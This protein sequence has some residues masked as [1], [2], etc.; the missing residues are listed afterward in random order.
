M[1]NTGNTS[2][3]PQTPDNSIIN[4]EAQEYPYKYLEPL[5]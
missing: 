2:Q 5:D 4:S 3:V 1:V